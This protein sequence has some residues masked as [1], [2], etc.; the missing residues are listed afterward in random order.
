MFT[1]TYPIYMQWTVCRMTKWLV[2]KV[3]VAKHDDQH[4]RH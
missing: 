2:A 1:D 4:S 3:E